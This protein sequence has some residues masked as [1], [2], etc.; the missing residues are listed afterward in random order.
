MACRVASAVVVAVFLL[1]VQVWAKEPQRCCWISQMYGNF[2]LQQNK[3]LEDGTIV[4]EET[5]GEFA[6]DKTFS[7]KSFIFTETFENGTQRIGRFV[8]LFDLGV[9]YFIEDNQGEQ[10]CLRKRIPARFPENCIPEKA[11]F[12][13]NVTL[14]DHALSGNVWELNVF[15]GGYL[16]NGSFLVAADYCVPLT[17][18]YVRY[19]F[20]QN[21]PVVNL[22]TAAWA[23]IRLGI[24]DRDK[25]FHIP[26]EC[27]QDVMTPFMEKKLKHRQMMEMSFRVDTLM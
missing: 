6:Y 5:G 15:G 1:V 19:D 22:I 13:N 24:C 26:D 2:A 17:N 20:N 27:P 10:R 11:E 18:N 21:P 16:F 25:F 9:S 12:F 8:D 23:D 7:A 3:E 14:G 4:V